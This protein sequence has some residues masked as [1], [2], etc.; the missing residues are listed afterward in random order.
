MEIWNNIYR[1]ANVTTNPITSIF[2]N[3]KRSNVLKNDIVHIRMELWSTCLFI[4]C[5]HG[6]LAKIQDLTHNVLTNPDFFGN[7]CW[8]NSFSAVDNIYKVRNKCTAF[9]QYVLRLQSGFNAGWMA[10]LRHAHRLALRLL[11]KPWV[12]TS[13]SLNKLGK[14]MKI[15]PNLPVPA[16][17]SGSLC[18]PLASQNGT[19]HHSKMTSQLLTSK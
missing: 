18:R 6:Y 7:N 16:G 14:F 13:T 2:I 12:L 5:K 3:L 1:H 8:S 10:R 4:C 17:P 19:S 9:F 11:Q 15:H